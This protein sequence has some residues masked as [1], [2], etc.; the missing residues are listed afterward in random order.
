ME[1]KAFVDKYRYKMGEGKRI[2]NMDWETFRK[3]DEYLPTLSEMYSYARIFKNVFGL[4]FSYDENR[5]Q[6]CLRGIDRVLWG[7]GFGT[8]AMESLKKSLGEFL[9][10]T[11]TETDLVFNNEYG[12]TVRVPNFGSLAELTVFLDVNGLDP[13]TNLFEEASRQPSREKFLGKFG[14]FVVG[15]TDSEVNEMSYEERKLMKMLDDT[16]LNAFQPLFP[17]GEDK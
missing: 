17:H 7:I 13:G 16:F 9:K 14:C 10:K 1:L 12:Y 8:C 4:E 15:K 6:T 11:S 5:S 2:G 3:L